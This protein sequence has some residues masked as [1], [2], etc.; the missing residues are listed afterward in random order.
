MLMKV[1]GQRAHCSWPPKPAEGRM[2]GTVHG[3]MTNQV[4][5]RQVATHYQYSA[6]PGYGMFCHMTFA[7]MSRE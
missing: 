7:A 2:V 4:D 3:M 1:A 6:L 5:S